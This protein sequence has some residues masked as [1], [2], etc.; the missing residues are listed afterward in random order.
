M[1]QQHEKRMTNWSDWKLPIGQRTVIMGIINVTP[2]SFSG[3]GLGGD[4]SAAVAQAKRM[5][6]E[7]ADLLAVG[8]QSTRPGSEP[9]PLQEE[10]SRV[11]PVIERLRAQDGLSLPISVDTNRSAVAEAALQAGAE[12]VND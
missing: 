1:V 4:V 5:A 7:G 2:D 3:D 12:I 11:I 8:G 6:A 9:V 10:L